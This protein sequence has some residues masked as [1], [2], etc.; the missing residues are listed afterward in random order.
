MAFK[1]PFGIEYLHDRQDYGE[2]RFVL[3]A[4]ADGHLLFV[5]YTE[6][7]GR[8]RLISARRATKYE[9]DDCYRQ[10]S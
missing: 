1:D 9:Q 7:E 4:M 8:F 2:D 6:R 3:I 10:N 5:A